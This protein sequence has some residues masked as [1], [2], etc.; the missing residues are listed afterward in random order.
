MYF[1]IHDWDFGDDDVSE[2]GCDV[3]DVVDV[4]GE[5]ES[6]GQVDESARMAFDVVGMGEATTR[7]M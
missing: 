6:V 2:T 1:K 7:P 4:E 5:T 3:S